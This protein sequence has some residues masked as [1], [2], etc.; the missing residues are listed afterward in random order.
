MDSRWA[1]VARGSGAATFATLTAAV[2]HTLAGGMPPTAFGLV[3]SLGLSA[4]LC[5]LLAG[6]GLS[7]V[8]LALAIGISQVLFHAL[9]SGLGTPVA[10]EH[11]HA[12]GRIDALTA[13]HDHPAMWWA[14][15]AAGVVTLL[16]FRYGEAAFWGMAG[17]ARLLVARLVARVIPHPI[18]PAPRVA[19]TALLLAPLSAV[20][21]AALRDRGPPR[22]FAVA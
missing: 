1:R 3:A 21:T 4:M 20:L 13:T 14:H 11:V 8:R 16:V 18:S 19:P 17:L 2:S 10:A 7:I 15:V 22:G 5:T 6:R 9:F 12:T